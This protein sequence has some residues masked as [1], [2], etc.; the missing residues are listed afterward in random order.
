[1]PNRRPIDPLAEQVH[2][3]VFAPVD[4]DE[5]FAQYLNENVKPR[6][7]PGLSFAD[8]DAL[9]QSP[10]ERYIIKRLFANSDVVQIFRMDE[11]FSGSRI[12]T[13]K[14][15]HQLKLILKIEV[16]D[17]MEMV[18]YKQEHIVQP[19]LNRR[20][21]QIQGKMVRAQHLAGACYTLAGS[22][23]EAITLNQFLQNQN[24][25]R[26]ELIDKILHQLR[27]SMEQLYA[28]SSDTELR[29]WAPLYSRILPTQLML[30]EAVLV[31]LD[32]ARPI[33]PFPPI[34]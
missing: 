13:V 27:V 3:H 15:S 26:K 21:G 12:Y 14:P 32:E 1:L 11:G 8:L 25:V 33:L 34:P 4:W 7:E 9:R 22:S 2:Q 31:E 17:R 23:D 20:V 19:R 6:I 29:Y 16:A 24:Q 18:Q 30:D 28:G 5:L 10:E